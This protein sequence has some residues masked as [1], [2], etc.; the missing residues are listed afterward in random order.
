MADDASTTGAE[1]AETQG[2]GGEQGQEQPVRESGGNSEAYWRRKAEQH[3]RRA[4]E[5]ERAQMTESERIKAERDE[6]LTR[7]TAAEERASSIL[8]QSRFEVEAQKAGCLDPE[9]AF[10]LVDRGLLGVQDGKPIG[11]GKALKALQESKPYLFSQQPQRRAG[12]GGGNPP[13][14]S[15]LSNTNQRMNDWLRGQR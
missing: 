9:A 1:G 7:A 13:G 14:G 11:I 8:L 15:H 2:Q 5:L 3:E 6:A 4:R 12:V 10:A